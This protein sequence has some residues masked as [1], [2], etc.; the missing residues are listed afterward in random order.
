M[1]KLV[2]MLKKLS[3]FGESIISFYEKE[4]DKRYKFSKLSDDVNLYVNYLKAIGVNSGSRVGVAANNC[5]EWLMA[6]IAL[7]EI[8]AVSVIFQE[9][10]QINDVEQFIAEYELDVLLLA[11]ERWNQL[12]GEEHSNV[13][14]IGSNHREVK[15]KPCEKTRYIDNSDDHSFVFS[16]GTGGTFKGMVID[17]NGVELQIESLVDA[18]NITAADSVY[19]FMPFSNFQQRLFYYA[20]LFVGAS[21]YVVPQEQIFAG[22]PRLKPTIL[23]APPILY[24]SIAAQYGQLEGAAIKQIFG[25]NIRFMIT[26]MAKIGLPTLE[27]YKSKNIPLFEVYGLTESGVVCVNTPNSNVIGSTGK[28]LPNT[29]I[30]IVEDGEVIVIKERPL[31]SRFFD[32][33]QEE[34]DT[35]IEGN[36]IYTGDLGYLDEAGHLFL[37]GRKKAT[38]ITGDGKKIQP[39]PIEKHLEEHSLIQHCVLFPYKDTSGLMAVVQVHL[40]LEKIDVVELEQ[41]LNGLLQKE[42]SHISLAKWVFTDVRFS[43]ENGLLTRNLKIARKNIAQHFQSELN[44]IITDEYTEPSTEIES[45]LCEI[46]QSVIRLERVGIFD[47]FFEIG[48]DSILSIQVV[49]Q[50]N[51]QGLSFTQRQLFE[52]QTINQLAKVV[53]TKAIVEALQDTVTGNMELLPIQD[54]FLN[55]DQTDLNYFIQHIS[56]SV[57]DGLDNVQLDQIIRALYQRHDALNL[58]FYQ[59]A[60]SWQSHF[61]ADSDCVHKTLSVV[62][63]SNEDPSDISGIIEAVTLQTQKSISLNDGNIFKAVYFNCADNASRLLLVMHHLV[64]DGISWRI[65][66][67]DINQGYKQLLA[68]QKISLAPKTSSFQQWSSALQYY[69]QS[70]NLVKELNYWQ[71]IENSVVTPLPV[72]EL[73][74]SDSTYSTETTETAVIELTEA[75]S[76]ALLKNCNNAYSTQINELLLVA[77]FMT[78]GQWKGQ[79]ES[80]TQLK[81]HIEGHGR[82]LL[83][84][85]LDISE[86]LGWFTSLYPL[87]LNS[88]E[89]FDVGSIIK[90]VKEKFRAIPNKGI[91]YGILKYLRK[92]PELNNFSEINNLSEVNQRSNTPE[93]LFNYLGQISQ[94]TDEDLDFNL[95]NNSV[96][97][98][99]SP[100]RPRSHQ[101]GFNCLVIDSKLT[102]KLDYSQQQFSSDT[103]DN[104]YQSLSENLQK[105]IIHCL[106]QSEKIYTPSDFPLAKVTS[107]TLALWQKAYPSLSN[108]YP[109]TPTQQGMVF[110]SLLD[111]QAYTTQVSLTL[112]G[113]LDTKLFKSA[114]EAVINRHEA[115]RTALPDVD[116]EIMHQLVVSDYELNWQ[117]IDFRQLSADEQQSE[118]K[119]FIENDRKQG[120][121]FAQSPLMRFTFWRNSDENYQLLWSHHHVLLDGWC[122]PLIFSEVMSCYQASLEGK[123]LTL[124]A[125][126]SYENYIEW[127]SLQDEDSAIYYWQQSLQ[128]IESRTVLAIENMAN[129]QTETGLKEI[130]FSIDEATTKRLN[131]YAKESS[132][133]LNAI[134]QGIWA[135]IL[136]QY[137]GNDSVLFGTTVSGRP[138]DLID[139][140]SMIGLFINTLPVRV[141]VDSEQPIKDWLKTLHKNQVYREENAFLPL[142][143]IQK[144]TGIANGESLF[145]SLIVFENYPV[146]AALKQLAASSDLQIENV[147]AMEKTNYGLQLVVEPGDQLAFK[148]RYQSERYS[149][150]SVQAFIKHIHLLIE[151]ITTGKE[152]TVGDLSLLKMEDKNQ[153]LNKWNDTDV[154]S[155]SNKCIHQLIEAQVEISPDAIATEYE[156]EVLSY[157]ELNDRSNQLARLLL[158]EGVKSD[159]IVGLCME[160][161]T[162][163]VISIFGILKAGAAYMPMDPENPSN[164]LNYILNDSKVDIILSQLHLAD[165]LPVEHQTLLCLDSPE[166]LQR[167]DQQEIANPVDLSD[168]NQSNLAY[169]IY[170]SGSTGQPKGVMVEHAALVNRINWMQSAYPIDEADCVLQKTPYNFDVSVWEFLWPLMTGAKMVLAKPGGHKNPEYLVDLIRSSKVTTL[171]FVPSMLS[172][173]LSGANWESCKEVKQVFSSGEA[174][175]YELQKRFFDSGSQAALINLYGPTEAAIDVSYWNCN[176]KSNLG[177]VPIGKPID[178]IQLY[179]LDSKLNP[180]PVGVFGEL[181]I[182]GVGLARGYLNNPDLTDE[183][184]I[185]NP[186]DNIASNRLPSNKSPSR[187]L[188]KT[189]DLAR[190]LP[191]GNIEYLS[192]LDGQIKIRG[193]R[194]ELGEIE[195]TLLACTELAGKELNIKVLKYCSVDVR[196]EHPGV[197]RLVA[198]IVANDENTN[199][200]DETVLIESLRDIVKTNLPEY[201]VPSAFILLDE[202]PVTSN[203]KL[204]R[205]ALA[206]LKITTQVTNKYVAPV[207]EVERA[208]ALIWGNI[209]AVEKVGLTDNFFDLGGDSI[210]AIQIIARMKA[211]GLKVTMQQF[212]EMKTIVKLALVTEESVSQIS[213]APVEGDVMLTPIQ[214]WFFDGEHKEFSYWNQSVLFT[215]GKQVQSALIV[216]TLEYL[217]AHHDG[218]RSQ[219]VQSEEGWQQK[220][221]SE[222]QFNGANVFEQHDIFDEIKALGN[223][224]VAIEAKINKLQGSLSLKDGPLWKVVRLSIDNTESDRLIFIFHHLI[225]DGMSW[226]IL[227]EDFVSTFE[228]LATGKLTKNPPPTLPMK[229]TSFKAWAEQLELYS[230]SKAVNDALPYWQENAAQEILALPTDKNTGPN[231]EG[232]A[233]EV[234]VRLNET[235]THTLLKEVNVAYRSQINDVLLTALTRVISNFSGDP[236]CVI[237][238]EGH[239]REMID[240]DIDLSR[241]LGWFTTMFP[242]QLRWD[243]DEWGEGLLSIKDQL[244]Q[245]PHKGLSYGL[246]KHIRKNELLNVKPA[247]VAFN[248]LGQF[249]GVLGNKIGLELADESTGLN[250][251]PASPRDPL[252]EV[253]GLIIN[254][255]LEIRW[256]YSSHHYEENTI[257]DLANEYV[258]SLQSLIAYCLKPE[259]GGACATDFKN[260]LLSTSQMRSLIAPEQWRNL[261]D[262]YPLSPLQN[263]ILFHEL[264]EKYELSST[265][266]Q[267]YLNQM[268]CDFTGS[269]AVD[270]FKQAWQ[271]VVERHEILRT[272]IISGGAHDPVQLVMKSVKL[273]VDTQNWCHLSTEQQSSQLSE[274]KDQDRQ[275]GFDF[276]QS[277]LMRLTLIQLAGNKHV[278]VWSRHHLIL[279]GWS[280]SKLLEEALQC[281]QSMVDGV[282]NEIRL[283][284]S[285][286]D[287]IHWLY[288]Q[289]EQAAKKYWQERLAGFSTV[290][291]LPKTLDKG[292]DKERQGYDTCSLTLDNDKV[293]NLQ[294]IAQSYQVT[295]STLIQG[296]WSLVLA[297]YSDQNDVIY[298]LTTSGR[299]SELPGVES[300]LGMFINSLP[301]RV[302]IDEKSTIAQWL[303]TLQANNMAATNYEFASLADIQQYAEVDQGTAL[304]DSLLVFENYPL[305]NLESELNQQL[306]IDNVQ[307]NEQTSYPLTLTVEM[308][309]T[310]TFIFNYQ[311]ALFDDQFILKLSAFFHELLNDLIDKRPECIGDFSSQSNKDALQIKQ[312]N[313]TARDYDTEQLLHQMFEMQAENNPDAIALAMEGE[314]STYQALNQSANNLAHYLKAQ[315]VG[316]DSCVGICLERS[317]DMVISYLAVLKAG[318]AY[319]PLDAQL[320]TS[321]LAYMLDNANAAIL[322]SASS[323]SF[324]EI[325]RQRIATQS[326]ERKIVNV[327][328]N[329]F[330]QQLSVQPTSNLGDVKQSSNN[331]A[332]VLYTSGTTGQPKGVMISHDAICNH[333]HWMQEIIPMDASSR[334]LQKTSCSFDASVWEFYA[335]LLQGGQ[336]HLAKPD[337][338]KDTQYLLKTIKQENISVL[339]VVPTLLRFLLEGG[340]EQCSSLTHV[341][342]GGEALSRQMVNDFYQRSN[343]QLINLYGPTEACIHGAYWLCE[344][345]A[346]NAPVP[347]GQPISNGQCFV[348]GRDFKQVP[349]GVAGELYI[350]GKGLAKGYIGQDEM[351][352]RKFITATIDGYSTQL[353]YKTGDKVRWLP[354]GQLEYLGRFDNQVKVRGHRIELEEIE[355]NLQSFEHVYEC[356]V[357]VKQLEEDA[358]LFAYVKLH[359]NAENNVTDKIKAHLMAL[360]PEYMVPVH[361]VYEDDLPLMNNG[362]IN[363]QVLAQRALL[364]DNTDFT[365]VA[366]TSPQEQIIA[367]IF[368]DVL[369]CEQISIH[370]RFFDIGGHS[371]HATQVVSRI[372]ERLNVELPLREFMICQTVHALTKYIAGQ[373]DTIVMQLPL[374]PI[375]RGDQGML[376]S[377]N[378][379]RLWFVEQMSQHSILNNVAAALKAVGNIEIDRLKL[380]IEQLVQRHEALRSR[381]V[382]TDAGPRVFFR[383]QPALDFEYLDI[384]QSLQSNS[385]D[386]AK[387]LNQ[388]IDELAWQPF[389]LTKDSLL[390]IKLFHIADEEYVLM[391]AMHHIISDGWSM[392]ILID[393]LV[394][395][396]HAK[397]QQALSPLPALTLQHADYVNWQNEYLDAGESDRQLQYWQQKL[398]GV[399]P[400]LS[401]PYDRPR[402]EIQTYNGKAVNFL[403]PQSLSDKLSQL[404]KEENVTLFMTLMSVFE[405]LLYRHSGQTDFAIGTPIANRTRPELES[406]VG[407]FI[408]TLV[409]RSDI[410]TG[411]RFNELLAKVAKTTLDAYGYQDISLAQLVN[412]IKPERNSS[413]SPFFQTWFVLQNA[414]S[415]PLSLDGTT[416][417]PMELDIPIARF[418][419]VMSLQETPQGLTGVLQYNTDLFDR[420]TIDGLIDSYKTLLEAVANSPD[421]L[422]QDLPLISDEAKAKKIAQQQVNKQTSLSRLK[423]I[424]RR[425]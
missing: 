297:R 86:T 284:A 391:M 380:S 304:F 291:A 211:S 89:L 388:Q 139:V 235:D 254:G 223:I 101:L 155:P 232:S 333:M 84:D 147:E 34:N 127:L 162:E 245:I 45:K 362:K 298:G 53:G 198:Y 194:I 264:L 252:I 81:L 170:T 280:T 392:G 47:N 356:A 393:D 160:R 37:I 282:E 401:L 364:F 340:L 338:H 303:Q 171:H 29:T 326:I 278:F 344:S 159:M 407:L 242:V 182:G 201:M 181:H 227:L 23:V 109:A 48:G 172:I 156:G 220:V 248:Y 40:P 157:R 379:E 289:D 315:G 130:D 18:F 141:D 309:Q 105:V 415:V 116:N 52:H 26:G 417:E 73:K 283:S 4:V 7:I 367:G 99:E 1:Y 409:I 233:R 405:I 132:T 63:L 339:Q 421:K 120:F 5:Y 229:T 95:I 302:K 208:I 207:T 268:S 225:I 56:V 178:N 133:T 122:L 365:F 328:D 62:N 234:K 348:L 389:D 32:Y 345:G 376:L 21:M 59:E 129:E 91:G 263:G 265:N 195:S 191:N 192:R 79:S 175:P 158:S 119:H 193:Q 240:S 11:P 237:S 369:K 394:A 61:I 314:T 67:K 419:L 341:G 411:I 196:E 423:R 20:A 104:L 330:K 275:N 414:P 274:F 94:S 200:V 184:F 126:V 14:I 361:F 251:H 368:C 381:F 10:H 404:S 390:R 164:R 69:S 310:V 281:Y 352:A 44:E 307:V 247:Q 106:A 292:I 88:S 373:S 294:A 418:D 351:T 27:L 140:D 335:P 261:Q 46:W 108:V 249:D 219:F 342:C 146:D 337:G 322:I 64:V 239:G 321:R 312:W 378:Q 276:S 327:D 60:G 213:Q 332:Y 316:T 279:D 354:D 43:T 131:K 74:G 293:G 416:F 270:M 277:P 214:S 54:Y 177:I 329:S 197:K 87:V 334:L 363:R 65:L 110:H 385:D 144:N 222:Q 359:D 186:F 161:S 174:L 273:N 135:Y 173:M 152:L 370:D 121:S 128:G 301:V 78:F 189:G 424:K 114:W 96:G 38:I 118:I 148:F 382:I 383:E 377:Q 350:A 305:G 92:S 425:S 75:D 262:M 217:V 228:Q 206:K 154:G 138:A 319:I 149:S 76:T 231:L 90:T 41:H 311:R 412:A 318:G 123:T 366:P 258:E 169:V 163:M 287:Y 98:A 256:L 168:V 82:E 422:L 347:I 216:E 253:E 255:E 386:R 399:A 413:Y 134:V 408:N 6:D 241:T 179:V 343:A 202:L 100:L 353:V 19:V 395:L 226:R 17:R 31:T 215:L 12:N 374:V 286:G 308:Q 300:M 103:I 295:L 190:W 397:S 167:I 230:Q 185:E 203:G 210:I 218:L 250:R 288:A 325:E 13:L 102:I 349:I 42:F 2:N 15:I 80:E 16:S 398:T 387:Q 384:R 238:I 107:D 124:A 290:S 3:T 55:G 371:L 24:E 357:I 30:E 257:T 49:A 50:A 246:L 400:L 271:T 224:S 85:E 183:K 346:N 243:S 296:L 324:S 331:L 375:E 306:H 57:P 51:K 166:I 39:E 176:K 244:N 35:R 323:I 205:K 406:I 112:K 336:L 372:R 403:L 125:P 22:L 153:L 136:Q 267:I 68:G 259:H 117:Q 77:L 150:G 266:E 165:R 269:L 317:F 113:K 145:D 209:L 402:P 142:H 199:N 70:D 83:F 410:E 25:G 236:R 285:Y 204:D 28:P 58:R 221:L 66:L 260:N 420:S 97:L 396:Y 272:A 115:L 151:Q 71:E 137:S 212:F 299:P 33:Q 9:N 358:L 72:D 143:V 355:I 360:L 180:L 188:Y 313:A 8:G 187:K 93:I 111:P 36:K 320:P